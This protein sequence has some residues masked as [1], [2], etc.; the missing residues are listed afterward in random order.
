MHQHNC[1]RYISAQLDSIVPLDRTARIRTDK[2]S[3]IPMTSLFEYQDRPHFLLIKCN[4][5]TNTLKSNDV[6]MRANEWM[7]QDGDLAN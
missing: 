6:R 4:V 7:A 2:L 3:Q 5:P 1:C